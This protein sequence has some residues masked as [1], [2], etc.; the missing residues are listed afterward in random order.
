VSKTLIL[1]AVVAIAGY[2]LRLSAKGE[3]RRKYDRK[4]Q[5]QWAALND[6]VDPTI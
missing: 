1:I 6:D 4:P 3:K 2:L 5:T